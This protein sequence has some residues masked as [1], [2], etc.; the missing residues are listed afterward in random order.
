MTENFDDL[1]VVHE[2]QEYTRSYDT[3]YVA[4]IQ[5]FGLGTYRILKDLDSFI[6][7]NKVDA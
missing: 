7:D 4:E 6:L 2:T 1:H 3:R 5:H